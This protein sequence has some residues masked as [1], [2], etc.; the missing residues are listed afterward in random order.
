VE[1]L[2]IASVVIQIVSGILLLR[3]FR[4]TK[5]GLFEKVHLA[6]GLYLAIFLIFHLSAIFLARGILKIDTNFYFG[7]AG[8]NIFPF[9]LFFIPYYSLAV[10][11]VFVHIATVHRKK[12][13]KK[14]TIVFIFGLCLSVL[15]IFGL[16]NH[17]NGVTLPTELL[18]LVGK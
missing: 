9:N 10:I 14:L 17:F 13:T 8:L 6:T 4:F 15:I 7:A 2:I 16:T 11:S 1:T 5:V 12:E 18:Q 3:K